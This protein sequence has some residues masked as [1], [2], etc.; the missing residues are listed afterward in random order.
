ML[1]L[2]S[3]LAALFVLS[4]CSNSDFSQNPLK[5]NFKEK[6][7]N[8]SRISSEEIFIDTQNDLFVAEVGESSLYRFDVVVS[9]LADSEKTV[10][11][12]VLNTDEVGENISY[13]KGRFSWTPSLDL[14]KNKDIN[15]VFKNVESKNVE[16]KN[17]ESKNVENIFQTNFFINIDIHLQINVQ[18]KEGQTTFRHSIAAQVFVKNLSSIKKLINIDSSDCKELTNRFR[19]SALALKASCEI[20]VKVPFFIKPHNIELSAL[21][22]ENFFKEE[23]LFLEKDPQFDFDQD[24]WVFTL[25]LK[26]FT[27]EPE[28]SVTHHEPLSWKSLLDENWKLVFIVEI[29]VLK[30][31]YSKTTLMYASLEEGLHSSKIYQDKFL[32]KEI[33]DFSWQEGI[34]FDAPIILKDPI[35]RQNIVFELIGWDHPVL[36]GYTVDVRNFPGEANV[37]CKKDLSCVFYYD[38]HFLSTNKGE[39][40]EVFFDIRLNDELIRTV[41]RF[42]KVEQENVTPEKNGEIDEKKEEEKERASK[43]VISD[44]AFIRLFPLSVRSCKMSI[45]FT[46][47]ELCHV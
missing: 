23:F 15:S 46:F 1:K 13:K 35:V 9:G 4:S 17:V 45:G 20:L 16:S 5:G 44:N 26:W 2:S 47:K 6:N 19:K 40:I 22:G 14:F 7:T 21:M 12:K 38:L 34:S 28:R 32:N 27:E 10:L 43:K 33:L 41:S 3:L 30:F 8:V 24:A 31:S 25:N 18:T 42:F 37:S 11:I 39:N 29:P 36:E